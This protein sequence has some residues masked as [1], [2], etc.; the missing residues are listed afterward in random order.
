M[1]F[2]LKCKGTNLLVTVI[3]HCDILDLEHLPAS[4]VGGRPQHYAQVMAHL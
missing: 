4:L 1:D 2:C 3:K